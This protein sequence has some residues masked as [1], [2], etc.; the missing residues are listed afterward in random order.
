MTD[1]YFSSTPTAADEDAYAASRETTE[2]TVYTVSGQD[3]DDITAGL[4][5]AAEERIVV[6][7]GP[8][9]PSTHG[10]LRLILELEG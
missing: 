8:Q 1:D 10:V 2:G 4:G 5:D 7:M 3:W 9:H 6:N